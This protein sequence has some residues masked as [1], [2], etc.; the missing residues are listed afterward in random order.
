MKKSTIL[1]L[2]FI[3]MFSCTSEVKEVKQK[4]EDITSKILDEGLDFTNDETSKELNDNIF[5][6]LETLKQ[7][8]IDSLTSIENQDKIIFNFITKCNTYATE[9][10]CSNYYL[11]ENCTESEEKSY[12]CVFDIK[13]YSNEFQ[14][15]F[16]IKME[17][18][19]TWAEINPEF[20]EKV[21]FSSKLNSEENDFVKQYIKESKTDMFME[22]YLQL[23]ANELF[24]NAGKW[25]D[26]LEKS[27]NKSYKG[28]VESYY[29]KYLS[30]IFSID[31]FPGLIGEN[32]LSMNYKGEKDEYRS[33]YLDLLNKYIKN[34][35][36]NYMTS[37]LRKFLNLLIESDYK[38]SPE[39]EAFNEKYNRY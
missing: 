22:I 8:T 3:T 33:D 37:D 36:N 20:L 2:L 39:I 21:L 17:E 26:I 25:G 7:K 14:E 35:P 12:L 31:N 5:S 29:K 27:E 10:E 16:I 18:G 1:P 9:T 19:F 32:G 38:I 34:N 30:T 23:T 4:T 13:N 24:T 15:F 11:E 28:I 6:E